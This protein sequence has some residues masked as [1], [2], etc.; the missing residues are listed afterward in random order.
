MNRTENGETIHATI[1]R[2][3][4]RPLNLQNEFLMAIFG[5][6]FQRINQSINKSRIVITIQFVIPKSKVVMAI[7]HLRCYDIGRRTAAS[8]SKSSANDKSCHEKDMLVV[9]SITCQ[10]KTTLKNRAVFKRFSFLNLHRH[11]ASENT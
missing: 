8:T 3:F 5:F 9:V 11:R 1:S 2:C 7:K 4:W 6:S 10:R